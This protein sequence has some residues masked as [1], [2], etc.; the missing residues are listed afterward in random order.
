MSVYLVQLMLLCIIVQNVLL[1]KETTDGKL[2]TLKEMKK[3]FVLPKIINIV[4]HQNAGVMR[5]I[6]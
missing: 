1:G 3:S 4:L 6:A 5:R 2:S